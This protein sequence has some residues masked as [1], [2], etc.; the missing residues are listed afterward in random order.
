MSQNNLQEIYSAV[1]S[2]IKFWHTVRSMQVYRKLLKGIFG[3]GIQVNG[4]P[5]LCIPV[6]MAYW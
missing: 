5:V 2:Q 4:I 6:N 3:N 1:L